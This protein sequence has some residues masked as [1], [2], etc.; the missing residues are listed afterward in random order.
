MQELN[1]PNNFDRVFNLAQGPPAPVFPA[2]PASGQFPLPERRV[3]RALPDEAAA[4]HGRRVQ[5]HRAASADAT[6]CRS[7]RDTSATAGRNVFAGD[8]PAT[9]VNQAI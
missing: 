4:A 7:R 3:R 8:G 6:R 2:V 5:R 9:N 1:A